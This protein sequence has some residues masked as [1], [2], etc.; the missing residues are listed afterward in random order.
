VAFHDHPAERH[1]P[2]EGVPC[3]TGTRLEGFRPVSLIEEAMLTLIDR[4]MIRGYFKAYIVCLVSLLSL[5]VVVDLFTHVDDF[6]DAKASFWQTLRNIGFYYGFRL[7]QIFDRLC[8]AIALMAAVF[9]VAW[10]QRCNEQVPLLS[11]GVSTRR[12]IRPVLLSASLMLTLI[13]INQELILPNIGFRL[14]LPRDDPDGEREIVAG[15]SY[16]P[17]G[18][19]IVGKTAARRERAIRKFECTIPENLA[20]RVAHLSAEEAHYVP[21]QGPRRGGWELTGARFDPAEMETWDPQVLEPID[22]GKYFLYTKKTDFEALTRQSTWYLFASTADLYRELQNPESSRLTPMAVAFHTRLTRPIIGLIL[23]LMGL[24]V[25]LRDQNRNVIISAGRCLVMCAIFFTTCYSCKM[26]GDNDILPPA[27]CAWVPV[28]GF[29]PLSFAM[30]DAV[31][32]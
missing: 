15:Y 26:L 7:T 24:A 14:L 17:N 23:V 20:G 3:R 5:Y 28:L 32:T 27:L 12:I 9:T 4:Q 18:L 25:I 21:G 22:S 19:H 30:F 31:H 29:G 8:E 16:E 1:D 11:A 2:V 10:M 6:G 13:I